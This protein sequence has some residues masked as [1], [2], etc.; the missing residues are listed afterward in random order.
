MAV[1]RQHKPGDTVKVVV[2]RAGKELTLDVTL[3]ESGRPQ[4]PD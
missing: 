3:T 2:M 1:P 4:K